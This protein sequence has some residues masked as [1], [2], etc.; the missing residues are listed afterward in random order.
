M[1]PIHILDRHDLGV[2]AVASSKFEVSLRSD[3]RAITAM[4]RPA[5]LATAPNKNAPGLSD[6]GHWENMERETGLASAVRPCR[7]ARRKAGKSGP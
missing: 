2:S 1:G 7:N 6:R 5:R 4:H 3:L